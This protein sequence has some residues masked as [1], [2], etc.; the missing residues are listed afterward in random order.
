MLWP[1]LTTIQTGQLNKHLANYMPGLTAKVFRT[2]NASYTMSTL[3]QELEATNTSLHEKIKLYN[4]CNRKVAILCNHKRTVGAGHEAQMGKL[5]DR[6]KGLKYQKWRTKQMILDLDPKQK[7]KKGA[8]WFELDD[9]LTEEWIQE[10]Q[11]FLV[12]EQRT[13]ITK[14]FEKDNEKL[15]A[16]GEKEMKAKELTERLGVADDLAKKLKK[17]NK[18]KKVEAEG[19]SPSVEKLEAAVEKID[20]RIT[21]MNLQAE[22]REGNKEVALGTSKI[23]S[24]AVWTPLDR[25]LT[26]PRIILIPALL[27]S[28][29]RSSMCPLR[30]SSRRRF[31]RSSTGPS[32]L[33]RTTSGN[34][35]KFQ[36]V[37]APNIY[38]GDVHARPFSHSLSIIFR[39]GNFVLSLHMRNGN[40]GR[41]G[42]GAGLHF[43]LELWNLGHG[44]LREGFWIALDIGSGP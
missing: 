21:T 15:V 39:K 40:G 1:I 34:S 37:Q 36:P 16:E 12:E 41:W 31:A 6:I 24:L 4:D 2:Y 8:E 38:N 35:R 27:S 33:W 25:L 30:S 20:Q 3:L 17:E 29:P 43:T 7:K 44:T 14:K 26:H 10:H 19:R 42:R 32:S 23:V 18:T 22:D 28:S 5:T 11:A 9:E 13:K